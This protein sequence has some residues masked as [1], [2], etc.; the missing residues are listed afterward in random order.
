MHHIRATKNATEQYVK[1]ILSLQAT[2]WTINETS[3]S[4]CYLSSITT[5]TES[6]PHKLAQKLRK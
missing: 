5:Q 3:Y 6:S 2:M 1:F 4:A